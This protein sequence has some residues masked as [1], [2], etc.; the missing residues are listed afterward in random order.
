MQSQHY[1]R[2]GST[3][4]ISDIT[5]SDI[6]RQSQETDQPL[7]ESQARHVMNAL[8]MYGSI[9]ASNYRPY[10]HSILGSA[11]IDTDSIM[12]GIVNMMVAA[13]SDPLITGPIEVTPHPNTSCIDVSFKAE[14]N[15]INAEVITETRM[16]ID[17]APD[18]QITENDNPTQ[19]PHPLAQQFIIGNRIAE[20]GL[21]T[22]KQPEG[23]A[24][25]GSRQFIEFCAKSSE[26]DQSMQEQIND[27]KS[28]LEAYLHLRGF[29]LAQVAIVTLHKD[30][31]Q[32]PGTY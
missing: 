22:D 6:I 21:S 3:S 26:S 32:N 5:T 18:L 16:T 2:G 17:F 15:H 25:L 11:E 1:E 9:I 8:R 29:D 20:D 13:M 12:F 28:V 24:C 4:K 27:G 19:R 10:L 14:G 23:W 30:P 7:D 31:S